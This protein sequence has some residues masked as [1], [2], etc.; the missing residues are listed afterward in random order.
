M[1]RA[2]SEEHAATNV[3]EIFEQYEE[4]AEINKDVLGNIPAKTLLKLKKVRYCYLHV[5]AM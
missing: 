4:W 2:R 5:F 1:H 3:A